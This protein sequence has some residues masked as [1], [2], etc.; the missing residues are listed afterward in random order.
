MYTAIINGQHINSRSM[1]DLKRKAS[2]ICNQEEKLWDDMIV[3]QYIPNG[4]VHFYRKNKRNKDGNIS[5]GKWKAC[6][7]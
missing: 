5:R 4:N 7:E 1:Q 2:I 3:L 6:W